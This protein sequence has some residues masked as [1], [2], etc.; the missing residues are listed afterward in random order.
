ML[1]QLDL[2]DRTIPEVAVA[3]RMSVLVLFA[4]G[5]HVHIDVGAILVILSIG[6]VLLSVVLRTTYR[7][8]LRHLTF[9]AS[10]GRDHV[11]PAPL[12]TAPGL[13]SGESPRSASSLLPGKSQAEHDTEL[14]HAARAQAAAASE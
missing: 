1:E 6:V 8:R 2:S 4:V 9:T 10:P 13:L 11:S 5:H 3:R 7:R 14:D 12:R